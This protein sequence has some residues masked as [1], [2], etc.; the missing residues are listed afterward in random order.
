MAEEK[1][2]KLSQQFTMAEKKNMKLALALQNA[3][4]GRPVENLQV[5]LIM[6]ILERLDSNSV[7]VQHRLDNKEEAN[8]RLE[9]LEKFTTPYC[10]CVHDSSAINAIRRTPSPPDSTKNA[11]DG[12]V[13]QNLKVELLAL[14][15]LVINI[16]VDF[17]TQSDDFRKIE[18]PQNDL[19]ES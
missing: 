16:I 11:L 6:E 10:Q 18:N 5:E 2:V 1:N 9:S 17:R 13:L 12:P 14:L 4:E 7:I 15:E 8:K 19:F 3:N